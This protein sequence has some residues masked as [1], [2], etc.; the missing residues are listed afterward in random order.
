MDAIGVCA[1]AY[2]MCLLLFV[3]TPSLLTPTCLGSD[4]RWRS[5]R[6]SVVGLGGLG[7]RRL[8]CPL[9]SLLLSS[10]LLPLPYG[11]LPRFALVLLLD[12]YLLW[13]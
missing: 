12:V 6:G 3:A 1:S 10:S 2:S 11:N 9:F 13:V 4:C 8:V 5:C 7:S